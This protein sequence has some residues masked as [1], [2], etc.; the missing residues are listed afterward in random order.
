[1]LEVVTVTDIAGNTEILTGFPTITRVRRVNGEKGIS[2]ILYPTEENTNSFPLVQEE[3]KIEFDGEVYIVKHLTERTIES[4]FYKRVECNHEFYVNMLN[5]Q[6]YAVHNGS[7]TFRD[8]VDFVFEGTGYQTAII[9]QFYAEDFQEFGK[10]N[11][12][13]LLKKILERYK[14]EISVRGNLASFKEKI[15]EDTDFQ[16]R[17]NYNIKTFERDIDTKPLATYI[18]GYGK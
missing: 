17:Y 5:K 15:G 4:K 7:M 6:K 18:R 14:A 3:S 1:M 13:A 8:A 12:L 16:F 10:E 9:D 2:F 11:R